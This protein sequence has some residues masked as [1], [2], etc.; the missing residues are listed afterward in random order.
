[1]TRPPSPQ[2]CGRAARTACA[3]AALLLLALQ[4][5]GC[6]LL[7]PDPDKDD[8]PAQ[9]EPLPPPLTLQLDVEDKVLRGLLQEHLDLARL[10]RVAP[11][12]AIDDVELARLVAAA[13][14]QV[15]ALL[16]TEGYFN[17]QVE[18]RRE[19]GTPPVVVLR[20]E[21]GPR[22]QVSQVAL[23]PQG[24]VETL[25]QAGDR[26]A[27]ALVSQLHARWPLPPEAPFR[28]AE[29]GD[30]KA[31]VLTQLRA[32]G[33]ARA[34]MADSQAVVDAQA[35]TAQ[36]TVAP[37]SGPLFRVGE[38]RIEG[39]QR[40]DDSTVRNLAG[41][42]PGTPAR[43]SL[44]LD[45]QERL[46]QAGLYERATVTLDATAEDPAAAPVQVQ[47][48]ELPRHQA[49]VTLGVD[50]NTGVRFGLEH[51]DR[52]VFD[53]PATMRNRFD[54]A[55]LRQAWDGE[56][57]SHPR[58]GMHRNL[59]SGQL[60]RLESSVDVVRSARVRL[61]RDQA[62][63][64][65]DRFTFLQLETSATDPNDPN[66][67][68]E[69]A[70]ALSI[71]H[72][73]VL[74]R[75]DNR[76]LPT[77]GWTLS[78]QAGVGESH[79]TSAASGPFT[80]L[81]GRLTGYRPL[82][83]WYGQARLELGQLFVRQD[84]GVPES[85][86]FRAG[87]DESVRGYQY[88]SLAPT[89]NGTVVSGNVLFTASAEIARPFLDNYPELWGALFVDVGQTAPRW[90]ELRPVWGPGVG[91]R[92]RSPVGPLRLDVAYGE[93]VREMRLHFSVGVTF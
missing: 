73:L 49:N 75:L 59:V 52:R 34:E 67:V 20:V 29:W 26:E 33:Y 41:F 14:A 80:R 65:R 44:L 72:H 10:R 22:V 91:L 8:A 92:Y 68:R 7:R 54:L 36:L 71:N 66:A 31:S 93:A 57:A 3:A 51:W 40:Q 17:P 28:N 35:H 37:D 86:Q 4:L 69:R 42:G 79:S 60:E 88:R 6:A 58:S 25:R 1:M 87:G 23:R 53:Q 81:Y 85:Q 15:R 64:R 39:L 27:A 77:R 5:G 38:L 74:R 48:R 47:L 19:D 11:R 63:P 24:E 32:G 84:V 76:L 30:A 70:S 61:G 83:A 2:R 18:L 62:T 56:L 12:A 21:P 78:L 13:P 16:E 89:V 45:Y 90:S 82:G 43:E 50:A 46:Q 9:E 55:Q